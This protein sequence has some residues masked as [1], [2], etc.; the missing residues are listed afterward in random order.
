[1]NTDLQ[2]PTSHKPQHGIAT[3]G[4]TLTQLRGA[5]VLLHRSD[6]RP[7]TPATCKEARP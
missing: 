5:R 2:R 6:G 3:M 4:T 7:F 1:M